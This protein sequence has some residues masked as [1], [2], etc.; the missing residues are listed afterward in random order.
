VR[1][2][3]ALAATCAV[4]LALAGCGGGEESLDRSLSYFPAG[5]PAVALVKT[6]LDDAQWHAFN[7][8]LAPLLLGVSVRRLL[9]ETAD[10]AG[11]SFGDDLKALLGNPLVVGE[12]PGAGPLATLQVRE[13]GKLSRVLAALGFTAAGHA[14][15]ARLYRPP[16]AGGTRLRRAPAGAPALVAVDGDVVL[17]A[18]SPA[19]LRAALA[20]RH[21]GGR[22]TER[23]LRR[24]LHGLPGDA[25]VR[26]YGSLRAL[27]GRA[28]AS[29]PWVRALRTYGVTV[30]LKR[31]VAELRGVVRTA[32]RT[33]TDA[34]LP[35][36]PGRDPAPIPV[37]EDAAVAG[38]RDAAPTATF[39]LGALPRQAG[40]APVVRQIVGPAFAEREVDGDVTARAGVRD[41][42]A[43]TR[44]LRSLV[45]RQR[46]RPLG[47][48][49]FQ[50][51][52]AHLV[53]GI[54]AGALVAGPDPA[55]ARAAAGE[56]SVRLA[57]TRGGLVAR[58][59]LS[60]LA[61]LLGVPPGSLDE[62]VAFVKADRA[63]LRVVARL[64]LP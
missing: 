58:A 45:S 64:A 57:S 2:I 19:T 53:V 36:A 59:E 18:A 49:L 62:A 32:A 31:H 38:L 39:L 9:R 50:A 23:E 24:G 12:M 16:V 60:V 4:G 29:L 14:R 40:L 37:R 35:L 33:V 6:D 27:A 28:P 15:G 17:A 51:R 25:L 13:P 43:A 61:P 7:G 41:A 21:R 22:L 48:G 30:T 55:R 11:L 47:G 56:A 5:A 34:Q 8:Q 42:A 20:A 44:A 3:V 52:G 1:R 63:G 54:V 10:Q 46:W 26:V